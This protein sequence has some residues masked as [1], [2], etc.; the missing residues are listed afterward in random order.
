MIIGLMRISEYRVT[1]QNDTCDKYSKVHVFSSGLTT[2]GR[3]NNVNIHANILSTSAT[4]N[5]SLKITLLIMSA[6]RG[7]PHAFCYVANSFSFG[8]IH[9]DPNLN[10]A[11]DCDQMDNLINRRSAWATPWSCLYSIS[12]SKSKLNDS[13]CQVLI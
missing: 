8:T 2:F 4:N 13:L 3:G 6:F 12:H 11:D 7:P 10:A 5:L 9:V 1:G